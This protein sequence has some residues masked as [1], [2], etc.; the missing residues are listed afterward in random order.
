[1]PDYSGASETLARHAQPD[2][3]E[4]THAPAIASLGACHFVELRQL[5]KRRTGLS[6]SEDR[7]DGEEG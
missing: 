6:H 7:C 5:R 2:R 4:R 3:D 1:M